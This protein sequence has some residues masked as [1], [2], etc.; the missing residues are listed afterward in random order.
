[1]SDNIID[2]T[3]RTIQSHIKKIRPPVEMRDRLDIGYT[4]KK[5]IIEIYE[6]QPIWGKEN[7]FE[8]YPYA[9]IKYVKTHHKWKLYWLRASGKW[10]SYNPFSESSNLEKMLSVIEEDALGCFKG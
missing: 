3:E 10:E 1:M 5:E 7:A 9:K 4:Y 6:R 2:I 8:N